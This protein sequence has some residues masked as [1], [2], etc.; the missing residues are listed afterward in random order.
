[1]ISVS[2]WPSVQVRKPV[3]EDP[4]EIKHLRVLDVFV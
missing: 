2:N 3:A 4:V 1:M